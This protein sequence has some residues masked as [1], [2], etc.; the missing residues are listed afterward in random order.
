M[1]K[2]V[3]GLLMTAVMML[4]LATPIISTASAADPSEWYST[5]SG[6]LSTDYYTL[7]P[8]EKNN[9]VIGF[10]KFG[11]LINSATNVALEYGEVDPYAYPAGSS[12]TSTVPKRMWVQG[13]LIN[14]SY[15]HRTLGPRNVW[16]AALHSDS[17]NYGND[18]IRVDF[19]NDRST[20]YGLEDPRDPGYLIYDGAGSYG[21]TLVNGGRKTNGTAVTAPIEVLYD[22]PREFIAVCRTTIKDHVA[23]GDNSTTSDVNLVEVAITIR[24][25]KVKK[26]VV[27]LKD[28]KSLLVE[29]EGLYMTVQFSNRGEVDLGIPATGVSSYAHFFVEGNGSGLPTVYNADWSLIRTLAPSAIS[30]AGAYPQVSDATFDYAQAINPAAGYVWSAAFWPSLSDWSIDGWDYWWMSMMAAYPHRIDGATAEPFIPFYIGEW[31][32]ELH[33]TLDIEGRTQFRGV[34]QYAVTNLHDGSDADYHDGNVVDAEMQYYLDETFNPWDLNAAVHKSSSRYVKFVQSPQP[35]GLPG[36]GQTY[37]DI[38]LSPPPLQTDWDEYCSNAERVVVYPDKVLL[39]RGVD[40]N[41]TSTGIRLRTSVAAGK[42]IKILWSALGTYVTTED[43]ANNNGAFEPDGDFGT[44]IYN[45][46]DEWPI[47]F[48]ILTPKVNPG[49][50]AKLKLLVEDVDRFVELNAVY[51]NGYLLGITD[52]ADMVTNIA[53]YYVPNQI[54]A[55][56]T[57]HFVQVFVDVRK[58][59][60]LPQ[61]I[62]PLNE[63]T[64]PNASVAADWCTSVDWAA[65]EFLPRYEWAT[66]GRDAA[67]VDSAGLALVTEAFDSFKQIRVGIAG[68]DM[69]AANSWDFMPNIMAKFS[70]GTSVSAYMDSLMR[71]ALADDWC[72]YWPVASSSILT[73]GGPLANLVAYYANDFTD[74][75]YG[76]TGF[77]G[78]AYSG[79]IAPITCWNRNWAR[80][81][82]NTYSS[83]ETVGYAVI[84]TYKDINGTVIFEVWGHWGRDTY[85]ATQWLH[86]DDARGIPPGII[87]LQDAPAGL[88]SI[89]LKID[90]TS[91]SKH[92]TFSIVEAL[93]TISETLWVHGFELKGGI[94]DP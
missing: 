32:F 71:A 5:V 22:G 27:L 66:V 60:S 37:Y 36:Y 6:V 73:T 16:A 41:L 20:T 83:S 49:V 29:K 61:T 69:A 34:T 63:D 55:G 91:S 8:F 31:D 47:E 25:D 11:E 72:T 40:Y 45:G 38:T 59:E 15:T 82:Y 65:L 7:Y 2:S 50:D 52:G 23:Y 18:W 90:F 30:K 89:I 33:H 78:T 74:A 1:K 43:N 24:F 76:I 3:I 53:E 44:M 87:Q 86:G 92:P 48:Y 75:F 67:T 80:A 62:D 26:C 81:G 12:E 13:W 28:V 39:K 88:T 35:W 93:G 51:L 56:K 94:H 85:Y 70:A 84:T 21:K 9:L 77:A 4:S 68:A 54:V 57:A 79:K 10:S 42:T 17:V 64:W 19:T 46:D 58:N 14:I